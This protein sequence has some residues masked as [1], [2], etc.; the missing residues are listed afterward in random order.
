MANKKH[1]YAWFAN[2]IGFE[3]IQYN[4]RTREN[5]IFL[6]TKENIKPFFISQSAPNFFTYELNNQKTNMS[7]P[8]KNNG[9]QNTDKGAQGATSETVNATNSHLPNSNEKQVVAEDEPKAAEQK[10]ASNLVPPIGNDGLNFENVDTGVFEFFKFD[11]DGQSFTGQL[12]GIFHDTEKNPKSP[13]FTGLPECLKYKRTGI[14][15]AIV[16]REW[17]SKRVFL[18][19]N[20]HQTLTF[21]EDFIKTNDIKLFVFRITRAKQAEGKGNKQGVIIFDIQRAL[22]QP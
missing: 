4:Y 19:P 2:R 16:M 8:N 13:E 21:F 3:V 5:K 7:K 22:I 6:L 20:H 1:P 9:S 18:L 15:T 11:K 14:E 12:I 17:E 10:A